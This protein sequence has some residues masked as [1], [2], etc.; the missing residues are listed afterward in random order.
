MVTRSQKTMEN[1]QILSWS[2]RRKCGATGKSVSANLN[3]YFINVVLE[4]EKKMELAIN[5]HT[6]NK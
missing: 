5:N 6:P 4:K 3:I 1:P 2:S